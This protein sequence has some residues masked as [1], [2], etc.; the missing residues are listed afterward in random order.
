MKVSV[1]IPVRNGH[2]YLSD[3]ID[4]V[5]NQT[6]R[7]IET[8][9]VNDGS[10]DE[11]KTRT[12]ARKYGDKIRYIE[13][14]NRGVAGAL[15]TGLAAMT[16]DIFCWLSHDDVYR[17]DKID[18][19]V[20]FFK[21]LGREDVVL[22][23]NYALIDEIGRIIGQVAMET[24][25]GDKPQLGLLRGCINGCTIFIPKKIF[26]AIGSFDEKLRFTQD[27]DMWKRMSVRHSFILMP[28]V[29]VNY[30]THPEQGSRDAGA[31]REANKLWINL[32]DDT[33]LLDRVAIAGSSLRFF[34]SQAEFLAGTPYELAT[35][36]A[37]R[38]ADACV[39]ETK[40][41]VIIPF[42]N[43]IAATKRA[44]L[45]A[46][47]QTHRNLEI[48]AISDGS[49]EDL[50]ELNLIAATDCRLRVLHQSNGGPGSARNL[51]MKAS[52][53]EYI[54]FL[55]SDDVWEPEKLTTQI[56]K[57]QETGHLFSHTSYNLVHPSRGLGGIIRRTGNLTGQVYPDIIRMCP[58]HTSTVVMHR[59][60]IQEAYFFPETFRTGED[61]LLW[62][63]IARQYPLLGIP[64]ALTTIEWSDTTAAV[65]IS[66]SLEGLRNIHDSLCK[67]KLHMTHVVEISQLD[68]AIKHM[69]KMRA[70][71]RVCARDSDVNV[72]L[73]M[74]T[75]KTSLLRDV[76][77]VFST[78]IRQ[79]MYA[80]AR[81]RSRIDKR[82]FNLKVRSRIKRAA[83]K[84]LPRRIIETLKAIAARDYFGADPARTPAECPPSL[85]GNPEAWL[86][87][88]IRASE[89]GRNNLALAWL[90][91]AAAFR[92]T[93]LTQVYLGQ[94][95]REQKDYARSE[96]HYR[97]SLLLDPAE[98]QAHVGLAILLGARGAFGEAIEHIQIAAKC[99][100]DSNYSRILLAGALV[101]VGRVDEA[102]RIFSKNIPINV[103][104]PYKTDSRIL[105]FANGYSDLMMK[106]RFV[107][108]SGRLVSD[109]AKDAQ[110]VY[111]ICCDG[112]YFERFAEA[113]VS[114]CMRNSSVDFII[115]IHLINRLASAA[116]VLSRLRARVRPDRLRISEETVDLSAFDVAE[117]RTYYACRRFYLLPDLVARYGRL[118]LCV[119][120]DQLIVGS[121]EPLLDQM[122]GYDVGLTHDPL[123]NLNLPSCFSA[124]AAFFA[125][126][127]AALIFADRVRHYVDF[128][129]TV[130]RT[131]LWH[132]DQA[133]LAV[134]YLNDPDAIRLW[135]FPISIV[136]SDPVGDDGIGDAIFWS[137]TYSIAKNIEKLRSNRFLEYANS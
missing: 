61:C 75:F 43:E 80:A 19:Q 14:K 120:A 5:L 113:A 20:Q 123:N 28:D 68:R 47:A 118:L 102:D 33:S 3:A 55:D 126:T 129:M 35:A 115:H 90:E 83:N 117:Q 22:F 62:I 99:G 100:L 13:Q 114:S 130:E 119:D 98:P 37:W 94:V 39:D 9:V 110:A 6:Y 116:S 12:V 59:K 32:T 66:R 135:R 57:M 91:K 137:I 122:R 64:A 1:V 48:V 7:N 21:D 44:I 111:F 45:S 89:E 25:I 87:A 92:D 70:K 79:P 65:S 108:T 106:S 121:V 15:N 131:P 4:S 51:G 81:L 29:L 84:V 17:P 128:F 134:T 107:P 133:A 82:L 23:T 77:G 78:I 85:E 41:S 67:S 52:S 16:G 46:L 86:R 54:A 10:N 104:P 127:E 72:E 11:G 40:A 63:D 60:L 136:Q 36:H 49:T 95:R 109:V 74:R 132:L 8:I 42:F 38:R 69:E 112:F 71:R 76:I 56:R 31:T 2:R 103:Q 93:A 18:R 124:T 96:E 50:T 58:I 125:P 53:G 34:R 101:N 88:A 27:Y 73:V 97:A 24:V 26:D 105:R 30:R